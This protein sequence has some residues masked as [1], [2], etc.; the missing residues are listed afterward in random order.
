MFSRV[1]SSCK[2]SC[3]LKICLSLIES[4]ILS[5]VSSWQNTCRCPLTFL[6]HDIQCNLSASSWW[7]RCPLKPQDFG[8]FNNF[9]LDLQKVP[10]IIRKHHQTFLQLSW[11]TYYNA[12]FGLL[13]LV[14]SADWSK[15]H[16]VTQGIFCNDRWWRFA[17]H[18]SIEPTGRYLRARVLWILYCKLGLRV[19]NPHPHS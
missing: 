10:E 11:M 19:Q 6:G 13:Q 1:V 15:V 12:L 17:G 2:N 18:Y 14:S 4:S 16:H 5:T 8:E 9:F 3:R 7:N